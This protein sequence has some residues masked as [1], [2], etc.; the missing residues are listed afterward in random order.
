MTPPTPFES[1]RPTGEIVCRPTRDNW[2]GVA[3]L[4]FLG[5]LCFSLLL[6]TPKKP[7]AGE[8]A[9][10]CVLALPF[11][12]CA[13]WTGVWIV[14]GR[15]IADERGLRWRGAGR[16]KSVRWDEVLDYHKMPVKSR[17]V[18]VIETARGKL[19]PDDWTNSEAL[20]ELVPQRARQARAKIWD[21]RGIRPEDNW[22]QTFRYDTAENRWMPLFIVGAML[23]FPL[24]IFA[25][26]SPARL[27]S[28]IQFM[29][30]WN[31]PGL[32]IAFLLTL[33]VMALSMPLLMGAI[34]LPLWRDSRARREESLIATPRELTW[35]RGAD[36]RTIRWEDVSDFYRVESGAV[37]TANNYVI[38]TPRQKIE[39]TRAL[40]GS[41]QLARIAERYATNAR[42]TKWTERDLN[43]VADN[44][45]RRVWTYRNNT[46][47]ALLW[48][49]AAMCCLPAFG[50]AIFYLVPTG[51]AP[52]PSTDLI[53][54]AVLWP[55]LALWTWWRYRA[56][57]IEIDERGITQHTAFGA[58]FLAWHEIES[59]QTLGDDVM[60]FFC[61]RSK[62]PKQKK[63]WVWA[64]IDGI[65]ELRATVARRA[66]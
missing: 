33:F 8:I 16:E 21:I 29:W 46:N 20:L 1:P 31:G 11:F 37:K 6:V 42:V 39:W 64:G 57:R 24:Q 63:I 40:G 51:T 23:V 36:R 52:A 27:V 45:P 28:S 4:L 62:T 58:R 38:E 44:A 10:V 32:T 12:L 47:R 65:D 61:V 17:T 19:R 22:P 9:A 5:A 15:I 59:G 49:L 48:L 60:T 41:L 56:A 43:A 50:V 2:I 13:I 55:L 66:G 53:V 14:R 26:S 3:L 25:K 54:S 35:Q 7:G 34:M 18:S 30:Q